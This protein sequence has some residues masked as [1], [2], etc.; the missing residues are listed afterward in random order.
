MQTVAPNGAGT[1]SGMLGLYVLGSRVPFHQECLHHATQYLPGRRRHRRQNLQHSL[2]H[3]GIAAAVAE[4]E[5]YVRAL[6]WQ[7]KRRRP[8][9]KSNVVFLFAQAVT[10]IFSQLAAVVAVVAHNA[11]GVVLVVAACGCITAR[12]ADCF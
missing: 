9:S 7:K 1:T 12:P 11:V 6:A 10:S 2:A 3:A 5:N 4:I 8:F